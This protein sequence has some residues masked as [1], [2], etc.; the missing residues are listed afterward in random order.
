MKTKALT[1]LPIPPSITKQRK[2]PGRPSGYKPEYVDKLIA[3]FDVSPTI[4]KEKISVNRRTGEAQ[5]T[6]EKEAIDLPTFERFAHSIGTSH[7]TLLEWKERFPVFRKA[8]E[9][10]KELQQDVWQTNTLHNRYNSAFAIFMG[11]NVFGWKDKS[12]ETINVNFS[13]KELFKKTQSLVPIQG[14][15]IPTVPAPPVIHEAE[16][17]DE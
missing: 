12:E 5:V 10:A 11:K 3:F 16:L 1:P 15:T 13:L 2:P 8:Y 4:S 17:E 9:R 6:E 14:K 7:K